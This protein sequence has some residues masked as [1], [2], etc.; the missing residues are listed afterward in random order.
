LQGGPEGGVGV[1]EGGD[2]RVGCE[3]LDHLVDLV[4]GT[5]S[6]KRERGE[7]GERRRR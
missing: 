6:G 7:A 1:E 3:D 5:A 4:D 2:G